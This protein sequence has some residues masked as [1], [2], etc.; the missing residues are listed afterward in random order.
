MKQGDQQGNATPTI[1]RGF[2]SGETD[3]EST[4]TGHKTSVIR[5]RTH[6]LDKHLSYACPGPC[7]SFIVDPR[8]ILVRS[9][10]TASVVNC[11]LEGAQEVSTPKK[12]AKAYMESEC[13]TLP[14]LGHRP[15]NQS[16]MHN[17]SF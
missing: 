17:L 10:F 8:G 5:Y 1:G 15:S 3:L 13:S 14:K 4:R 2:N 6:L 11:F 16:R 9:F 12:C 7:S